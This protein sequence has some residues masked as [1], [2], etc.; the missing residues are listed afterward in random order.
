MDLKPTIGAQVVAEYYLKNKRIRKMPEIGVVSRIEDFNFYT[1]GDDGIE[2]KR[3]LTF[4]ARNGIR[5]IGFIPVEKP[6][7]KESKKENKEDVI[8]ED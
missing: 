5:L 2:Y 4:N 6:K 8:A 7:K 3:R 1:I